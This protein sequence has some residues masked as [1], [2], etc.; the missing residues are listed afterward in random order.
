[1][2]FCRVVPGWSPRSPPRLLPFLVNFGPGVSPLGQKVKNRCTGRSLATCDKLAGQSRGPCDK[3][4]TAGG[5]GKR[6]VG[7]MP[8][9]I[10]GVLVIIVIIVRTMITCKCLLDRTLPMPR[11][12]LCSAG[13]YMAWLDTLSRDMP[14]MLLLRGNQENVLTYYSWIIR[15]DFLPHSSLCKHSTQ[16]D[17]RPCCHWP[18][19]TA[20]QRIRWL[21]MVPPKMTTTDHL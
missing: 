7:I 21:E 6:H 5:D 12:G 16:S 9:R 15:T 3:L 1:M 10:T 11:K 4:A 19:W 18:T 20:G 2:K 13:L 14:P 17:H 8:V